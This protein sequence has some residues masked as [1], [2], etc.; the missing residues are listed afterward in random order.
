FTPTFLNCRLSADSI[1]AQN[2]GTTDLTLKQIDIISTPATPN[3]TE[4]SFNAGSSVQTLVVNRLF[5]RNHV[6]NFPVYYK[7]TIEGPV[8][9]TV[10]CTWDSAGVKTL[11]STNVL[12][13]IGRLERDTVTP[14]QA[15]AIPYSN[16]TGNFID[17]PI[18]LTRTLPADVQAMGMSFSVT[19]R[20]DLLDVVKSKLNKEYDG[21]LSDYNAVPPTIVDDGAGNETVTFNL[22]SSVPITTLAPITTMHFEVMVSRD[23]SSTISVSNAVFWGNDPTDTLCYVINEVKT[24]DFNPNPTC[25]DSTLRIRLNGGTPTRII[26]IT[27]NPSIEGQT[28]V[29]TYEVKGS[30]VPVTIELFNALGDRI[31]VIEKDVLHESGQYELP[32]GLK[33]MP[34]GLYILRITTPTSVESGQ[35][36]IQK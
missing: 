5:R 19:Y 20:R 30:K 6:E 10:K 27:P 15:T 28:P 24:A 33:N 31:R 17:V 32:V 8:S 11:Y 1:Q 21:T 35:F 29:A 22:K 9:A 13:G 16:T 3:P 7:P 4:F 26:G 18:T 36:V 2:K 25:G 34:S 12:T 14:I 23:Y